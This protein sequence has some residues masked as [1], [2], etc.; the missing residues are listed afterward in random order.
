MWSRDSLL[1]CI[2]LVFD[3]E[4]LLIAVCDP[5]FIWG[6]VYAEV[7]DVKYIFVS[8]L[9]LYPFSA[10]ESKVKQMRLP[11]LRIRSMS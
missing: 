4:H 6:Q 10:A 2:V 8:H 3:I 11:M 5:G 9:V 7:L 1:Y